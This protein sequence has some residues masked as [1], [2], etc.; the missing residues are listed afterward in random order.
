V[1]CRRSLG[2]ALFR[3]ARDEA[4]IVDG[5]TAL[6]SSGA[7]VDGLEIRLAAI[8]HVGMDQIPTLFVEVVA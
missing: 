3:R 2:L 7:S 6:G 8:E 4:S 1:P 5:P